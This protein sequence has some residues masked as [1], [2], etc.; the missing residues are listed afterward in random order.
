M[1]TKMYDA[2]FDFYKS[3]Y[4]QIWVREKYKW[5][6]VQHFKDEWDINAKDFCRMIEN[7]LSETYNLMD[8]G[9]YYP[10]E[11]IIWAA[12]KDEEEVRRLFELLF[13][14]SL[15][16]KERIETFRKGIDAIVEKNK[17]GSISK[18]YQDHRAVMVYL[19]LRYP[20]K[21][22]LYKYKIFVKFAKLIDYAELPK[23]GDIEL[24]FM[25]ESMCNMIRTRVMQDTELLDMY[26]ERRKNYYDPEYH[27]L[28]QDI[29]Y[30]V[31]YFDNPEIL[32]EKKI[33]PIK[34]FNLQA[35]LSLIQLKGSHVD[36]IE[37]TK[38]NKQ[39]G[40]A[41][42]EF[43]YQYEREE[44]KEYKLSKKKQVRRVAKLDGDGLGYDIL[45]YDKY[46]REKYIE[47][48]TTSGKESESIFIT[49]NELKMSEDYPEQYYLY[50][51]Y[52]FNPAELT[53]KL[54]IRKGPLTDLC[55]T[56]QTYKMDFKL[57]VIS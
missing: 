45:S 15:D 46:G 41:G 40:D 18:S 33:I 24:V 29:V 39:I 6:A 17:E 54:S 44:I 47:V 10:R 7:A 51:V 5:K 8:A 19:S 52:D 1:N 31:I 55:I 34:K 42:E 2:I 28:V 20:E 13:D 14:I 49:A 36:Y 26:A 43:V 50:R 37:K 30:S 3:H 57:L 16:L 32:D 35:K 4:E 38:I 56:A 22:Y 25:F 12:N 9:N 23:A 48:K 53:G 11:M 21:Y 27:L